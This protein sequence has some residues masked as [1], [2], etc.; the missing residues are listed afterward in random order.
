MA[1]VFLIRVIQ[2]PIYKIKKK[3]N[4]NKKKSKSK[5]KNKNKDKKQIINDFKNYNKNMN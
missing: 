2:E 4:K 5:S 3:I 1:I